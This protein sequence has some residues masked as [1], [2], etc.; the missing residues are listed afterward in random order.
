M[1][2]LK[3]LIRGP[4]KSA[5]G[6]GEHARYLLRALAEFPQD[7]DLYVIP[8]NWGQTN[9]TPTADDESMFIDSLITKTAIYGKNGG[10]F[11]LSLQVTIPNEWTNDLAPVNIGVTA[12]IETSKVSPSWIEKSMMMNHII[13]TSDHSKFTYEN[14]VY[15]ARTQDGQLIDYRTSTPIEVVHYP[16]KDVEPDE[17]FSL[18]LEYDTNFL[19]VLQWGPRKN[20]ENTIRWFVEDNIDKEVGLVVKASIAKNCIIDRRH[21]EKRLN[22][23][24]S[25]YKNR[26]CKV[27]LLHG[28]M[29]EA[30]MTA[31]Y[32]HP[33]IKGYISLTHGEGYGLPIFEAVYNELPVIAPGWSGH[34]DFLYMPVTNKKGKTKLKAMFANVDFELKPIQQAAVWQGVLEP[35]SLWCYPDRNSFRLKLREVLSDYSRFKSQ[36]VKLAEWVREEF[37][38]DKKY[39][40]MRDSVL[41]VFADRQ[42][43]EPEVEVVML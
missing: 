31:L 30:E 34:V 40:A 42:V 43:E 36:A 28:Y 15:K 22:D 23:L 8:T 18:D 1:K 19:T 39:L 33:Q 32:Q 6:Y 4:V 5:S 11:D 14:T 29:S 9:W 24:L 7:F 25:Q 26:K 16:V 13:I 20:L 17:S 10:K 2:R 12:G 21:A 3:A 38:Q 35:D 37:A 27:Y 41:S